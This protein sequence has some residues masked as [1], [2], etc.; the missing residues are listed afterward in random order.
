MFQDRVR[1]LQTITLMPT[2][3]NQQGRIEVSV[4]E[5]LIEAH[6]QLLKTTH[7]QTFKVTSMFAGVRRADTDFV[8]LH[9]YL[10]FNYPQ[11]ILPALP[12]NSKKGDQKQVIKLTRLYDRYLKA[13][14]R[15]SNIHSQEIRSSHFLVQFLTVSDRKEFDG[16]VKQYAQATGIQYGQ[17]Y[18]SKKFASSVKDLVT[19]RGTLEV[20]DSMYRNVKKDT[21]EILNAV[22]RDQ[23]STFSRLY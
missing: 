10:S 12:N 13:L 7:I 1:Q 14:L 18:N 3:L 6:K 23:E 17:P 11:V 16:I 21:E 20:N 22:V 5:G 15:L 2:V 8:F 9:S 19:Q 4:S